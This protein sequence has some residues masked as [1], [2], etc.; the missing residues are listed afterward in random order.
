MKTSDDVTWLSSNDTP[1]VDAH[2]KLCVCG[3]TVVRFRPDCVRLRCKCMIHT[4][5]LAL[6]VR[7]QLEDSSKVSG[8]GIRC[9]YWHACHSYITMDDVDKFSSFIG[10]SDTKHTNSSSSPNSSSFSPGSGTGDDTP[11]HGGNVLLDFGT[12]EVDK[13][14]RFAVAAS[15][16]EK[17]KKRTNINFYIDKHIFIFQHKMH[18]LKLQ[19]YLLPC[20]LPN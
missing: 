17:G 5:C 16:E 14:T 15:F 10:K 1:H 3:D 8:Q 2:E 6:Y 20:T 12:N 7:S 13:F 19:C 4:T 9:C 18:I 11:G